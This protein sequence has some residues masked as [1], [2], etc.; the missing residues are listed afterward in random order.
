MQANLILLTKLTVGNPAFEG[1]PRIDPKLITEQA[2]VNDIHLTLYDRQMSQEG[3]V[4]KR[5]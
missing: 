5:S 1:S 4:Y 3:F 2:K